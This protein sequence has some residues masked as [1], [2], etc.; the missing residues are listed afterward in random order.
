MFMLYLHVVC[1]PLIRKLILCCAIVHACLLLTIEVHVSKL[2]HRVD[3]N[4]KQ[5]KGRSSCTVSFSVFNG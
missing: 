5:G 1:R 2:L 4:G 3:I